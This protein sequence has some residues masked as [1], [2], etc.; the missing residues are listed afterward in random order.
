MKVKG[1]HICGEISRSKELWSIYV[2]SNPFLPNP[3][4]LPFGPPK[5]DSNHWFASFQ[6][7]DNIGLTL[8]RRFE[9]ENSAVGP[10]ETSLQ[11]C[12]QNEAVPLSVKRT[13][14]E[15]NNCYLFY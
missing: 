5:S 14:M 8:T 9:T 10:L 6:S 12:L 4:C 7:I 2:L 1:S 13:V 3:I 11:Q 15:V